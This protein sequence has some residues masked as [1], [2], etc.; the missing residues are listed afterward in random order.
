MSTRAVYTVCV[1]DRGGDF[2]GP[3]EAA[4]IQEAAIIA[5]RLQG[6]YPLKAVR[7][8]NTDRNDLDF[9]GLTEEDRDVLE[10]ALTENVVMLMELEKVKS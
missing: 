10:V 3:Y 6:Q 9:D 5:A 7:T 4:T 1:Y 8:F 2:A